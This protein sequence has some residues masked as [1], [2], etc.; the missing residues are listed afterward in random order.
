M[1]NQIENDESD[2]KVLITVYA[3]CHGF[4]NCT[5]HI[6]LPNGFPKGNP[7]EKYKSLGTGAYYDIEGKLQ[8]N[9]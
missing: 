2:D 9:F 1:N 8:R 3:S 4:M 5:S 6:Y 7:E